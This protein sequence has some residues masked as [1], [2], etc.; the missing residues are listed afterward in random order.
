MAF[1]ILNASGEAIAINT[2]DEEVCQLWNCEVQ[3]K[4][5]A[6]PCKREAFDPGF[7]GDMDYWKQTNWFDSVGFAILL[8]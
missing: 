2:L 5:Y 1:Q 6:V 3:A 4:S 8:F 7:K